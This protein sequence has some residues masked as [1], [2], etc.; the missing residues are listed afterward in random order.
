MNRH[1]AAPFTCKVSFPILSSSTTKLFVCYFSDIILRLKFTY[2][3][4]TNRNILPSYRHP[5][6]QTSI[7]WID[8]KRHLHDV[9]FRRQNQLASTINECHQLRTMHKHIFD[10]QFDSYSVEKSFISKPTKSTKNE[11]VLP[12]N[13]Y[14]SFVHR[15]TT[16]PMCES[17]YD[18]PIVRELTEYLSE[19]PCTLPTNRTN[20]Q[21]LSSRKKN[22]PGCTSVS[23]VASIDKRVNK[24]YEKWPDY[25]QISQIVGYHVEKVPPISTSSRPS[26]ANGQ[27]KRNKSTRFTDTVK[28]VKNMTLTQRDLLKSQTLNEYPVIEKVVVPNLN[29]E[30]K[31][32][33]PSIL[34]PSSMK[35]SKRIQTRQWLIKSDFSSSSSCTLPLI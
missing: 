31:P 22:Q 2:M 28:Q 4:T 8:A 24:V 25:T 5:N 34:C 12:H 35:Y 29:K 1:Y 26:N 10:H 9:R 20:N 11:Y 3:L 23:S 17:E 14:P 18:L 33:L 7:T 21:L 27:K 6:S 19:S 13:E 16:S 15:Q 32:K 30:I